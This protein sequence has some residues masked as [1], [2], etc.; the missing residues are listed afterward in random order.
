MSQ[1]PEKLYGLLGHPLIHS[2]SQIY[3]N[4]KFAAENSSAEY[5]NFDIPGV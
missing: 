4:Q 2:F 3:F 1:K 5:I